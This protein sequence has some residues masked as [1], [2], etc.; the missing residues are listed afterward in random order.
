M[1]KKESHSRS[2]FSLPLW[3]I[4]WRNLQKSIGRR[5]G[6]NAPKC[7]LDSSLTKTKNFPQDMS[8]HTFTD[9]V[10]TYAPYPR[11]IC[12][13]IPPQGCLNPQI[14]LN[15]TATKWVMGGL[16]TQLGKAGRRGGSG[17]RMEQDGT[18][19][20][21]ATQMSKQ[22]KFTDYPGTFHL[23][24]SH[25]WCQETK[26]AENRDYCNTFT[27]PW[28]ILILHSCKEWPH[29]SLLIRNFWGK[30]DPP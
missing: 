15:C 27:C 13:K 25:R 14:G 24:L 30:E 12:S 18:R 10:P 6:G 17:F 23:F 29:R 16:H 4:N 9:A 20:H 7:V 5:P 26:T 8:G 3:Y 11:K 19:V 21:H 22:F 1:Y 28:G 2:S